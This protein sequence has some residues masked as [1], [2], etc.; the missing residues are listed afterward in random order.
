MKKF[1]SK[2]KDKFSVHFISSFKKEKKKKEKRKLNR[3]EKILKY[4]AIVLLP[5]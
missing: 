3:R 2:V 5:T 1:F 4:T